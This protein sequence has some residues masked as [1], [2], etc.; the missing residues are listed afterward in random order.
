MRNSIARYDMSLPQNW[1]VAY[2]RAELNR[3]NILYN[4]TN[5]KTK[6]IQL[7]R[8]NGVLLGH[9]SGEQKSHDINTGDNMLVSLTKKVAELKKLS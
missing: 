6:L 1:T 3:H 8:D 2:L 5:K 7:C 4:K 9:Q